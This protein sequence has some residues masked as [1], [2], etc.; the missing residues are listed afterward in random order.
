MSSLLILSFG[1]DSY[2]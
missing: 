2:K 1:F